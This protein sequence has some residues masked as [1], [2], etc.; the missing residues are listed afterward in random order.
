[1]NWLDEITYKGYKPCKYFFGG[2]CTCKDKKH[3]RGDI[4]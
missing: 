4:K 3:T 1:M 2:E